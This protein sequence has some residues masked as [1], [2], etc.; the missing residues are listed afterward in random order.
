MTKIRIRTTNQT[1]RVI[2]SAAVL[3]ATALSGCT[4]GP[5]YQRPTAA[6]AMAP[7]AYKEVPQPQNGDS[8]QVASPQDAMLRGKWWEVFKEPELN[9][10]EE[11]LNVN[12]QNIQISFQN[13][14]EARTLIAQARAQF[15]PTIS[16]GPSWSRSRSSGNL[17]NSSQANLSLIHI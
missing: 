5:K 4:V 12:N 3:L 16:I 17:Q 6:T 9:A 13:F 10:L 7:A 15:W 11:Q 2:I 14:M 8:W 1:P